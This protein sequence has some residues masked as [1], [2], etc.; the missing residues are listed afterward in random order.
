MLAGGGVAS[1]AA[2]RA[3]IERQS[4]DRELRS[5]V[6][7]ASRPP[8]RRTAASASPSSGVRPAR[9]DRSPPGFSATDLVPTRLQ[10]GS[11]DLVAPVVEIGVTEEDGKL[12][13]AT[14]DHAIGHHIGTAYP[15]QP[16]NCVMSGLISSPRRGEGNIFRRLPEVNPGDGVTIGTTA[17]GPWS[18]EVTSTEVVLPEAIEVMAQSAAPTLTL[19]TCVPDGV[20]THRLV[21]HCDILT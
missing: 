21:V 6:K 2:V 9:G 4:R 20:F 19:I 14:A 18:Y 3:V 12:V 7:P 1:W 17:A 16:G 15:G 8:A 13:W 5:M 11:I 10:I